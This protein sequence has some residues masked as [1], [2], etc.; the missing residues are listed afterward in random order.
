M[1]RLRPGTPGYRRL[2]V[3]LCAAEPYGDFDLL[4]APAWDDYGWPLGLDIQTEILWSFN[5]AY[6]QYAEVFPRDLF[7]KIPLS[8]FLPAMTEAERLKITIRNA[9]HDAE[10]EG[11]APHEAF[12]RAQKTG[13]IVW[14]IRDQG[15]PVWQQAL[16]RLHA[17]GGDREQARQVLLAAQSKGDRSKRSDSVSLSTSFLHAGLRSWAMPPGRRWVNSYL[18]DMDSLQPLL[19]GSLA[20]SAGM[21]EKMQRDALPDWWVEALDSPPPA[22]GKKKRR[23]R[24]AGCGREH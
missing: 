5:Y 24:C 4:M 16:N 17:T 8:R 18:L 13:E 21:D 23:H 11:V 2:V 6:I 19:S 9:E 22:P 14:S 10:A 1:T 15:V 12:G 3:E 7:G 20:H